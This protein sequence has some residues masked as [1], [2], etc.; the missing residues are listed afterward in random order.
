MH[1]VRLSKG[2]WTVLAI[3]EDEVSCALLD[4][5]ESLGDEK[6]AAKILSDLQ[7]YVPNHEP[8]D[9]I[10]RKLSVALTDSDGIL[11]F[12]WPKSKGPTPRILWF[13]D[14]GKVVVCSHGC[15]KKGTMGNDEIEN[16]EHRKKSYE[17]DR[18]QD[19]LII[20]DLDEF[21]DGSEKKE[22]EARG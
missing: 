22:G 4:F 14:K 6:T 15:A 7:G 19:H 9:W 17:R 20:H 11:E 3:C 8:Q 18:D 21:I 16:A 2:T 5:L 12:R 10:R 1:L 13:Y